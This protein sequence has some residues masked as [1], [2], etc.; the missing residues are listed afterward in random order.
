MKYNKH[1]A[2][3]EK[4]LHSPSGTQRIRKHSRNLASHYVQ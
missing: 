2:K 3:I 1:G 4:Y